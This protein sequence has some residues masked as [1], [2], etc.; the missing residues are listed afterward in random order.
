MTEKQLRHLEK[1]LHEERR[2][3]L[4]A[5][6]QFDEQ[7]RISE[8]EADGDLTMYPLHMAD[9]GTDTEERE[10]GFLL[11]S[12]EGRRVYWIDEALETLYRE[13]ER[14]GRCEE[15]GREIPFE[16]LEIVPWARLCIDCQRDEESGG[17]H[18][19]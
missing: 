1:R 17:R 12:K 15:C 2:R 9:G 10:K 4:K 14:Y 3:A 8:V 7:N 16:R 6:A 19:A 13:P 11:A 18:A 5:L